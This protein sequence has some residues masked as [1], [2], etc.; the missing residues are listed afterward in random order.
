MLA[1]EGLVAGYGQTR[2][3]A[4]ADFELDAG[5]AAVLVGPSGSGKTTLLLALAGLTDVIA[6]SLRLDGTEMA[7]LPASERDRHRGRHIGFIF[8]D[9]YLVA[10]LT[11]LDNLLLAPF[12]TGAAQD[13]SQSR[14]LLDRLGL[15]PL[16]DRPAEQLSRGEAQRAA[17]ARAMLMQPSLILADE[18][19]ASLDDAACDAALA[20]L[21]HAARESGAALLIASHDS[22]VKSRIARHIV[23]EP[24]R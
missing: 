3:A 24:A 15:G 9:L 4:V 12:A 10:G 8:Q 17:I 11:T 19:T 7:R 1:V 2:V 13:A 18:P 16:A 14:A 22:R 6:G 20:L 23:A 5:E 21:R